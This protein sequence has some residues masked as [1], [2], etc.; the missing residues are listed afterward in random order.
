VVVGQD[1]GRRVGS[2]RRG[3]SIAMLVPPV[4][5]ELIVQ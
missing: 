5:G 3:T 2:Q 4:G 1:D